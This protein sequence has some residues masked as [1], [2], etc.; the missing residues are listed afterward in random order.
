MKQE[1]LD[2]YRS[3]CIN[4]WTEIAIESDMDRVTSQ[5]ARIASFMRKFCQSEANLLFCGTLMFQYAMMASFR[6]SV[7]GATMSVVQQSQ[8][9]NQPFKAEGLAKELETELALDR[10]YLEPMV[11]IYDPENWYSEFKKAKSRQA[12]HRALGPY[13]HVV[14]ALAG[15]K[16]KVGGEFDKFKFTDSDIGLK[17]QEIAILDQFL[18][19]VRQ[20]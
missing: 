17:K 9:F 8:Y 15:V 14:C 3:A 10:S 20:N 16:N 2:Q 1:H 7:R 6:T 4:D 13:C 11:T 5:M 18:N 19:Q 12:K